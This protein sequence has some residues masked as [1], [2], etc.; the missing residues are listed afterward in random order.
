LRNVDP[1]KA[2][3]MIEKIRSDSKT[4]TKDV[5]NNPV[6][7]GE[8]S[9]GIA[10]G[11]DVRSDI[12]TAMK[13]G[14]INTAT[15]ISFKK[16]LGNREFQRGLAYINKSLQPSPADRW[17]PDRNLRHAEAIDDYE[18]RVAKGENPIDVARDIVDLNVGQSRRSLLG[19]RSPRYLTGDKT[20]PQDLENAKRKTAEAFRRG[21]LNGYEFKRE[22]E[23]IKKLEELAH[24]IGLT[25][26]D[27]EMDRRLKASKKAGR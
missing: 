21:A 16:Q 9:E 15:Y 10:L 12:E 23:I 3:R 27:E 26:D 11:F 20:N 14:Q 1:D 22:S 25:D 5:K 13:N 18:E 4:G 6:V 17:T 7:V 24:E 19:L 8:I 2:L